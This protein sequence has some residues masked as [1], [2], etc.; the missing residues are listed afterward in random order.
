[1]LKAITVTNYLLLASSL[2]HRRCPGVEE[3]STWLAAEKD[4]IAVDL[5]S[6]TEGTSA[7]GPEVPSGG[8]TASVGSPGQHGQIQQHCSEVALGVA[9]AVGADVLASL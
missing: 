2:S 4:C 5:G 1:M 3:S 7:P 6:P 9:V 8:S